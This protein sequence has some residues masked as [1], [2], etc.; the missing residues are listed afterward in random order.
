[1]KGMLFKGC[2]LD[3]LF[4]PARPEP[5]ELAMLGLDGARLVA[6]HDRRFYSYVQRLHVAGFDVAAVL[7]RE[8]FNTTNYRKEAAQYAR[9]L[10]DWQPEIYVIGNEEDAGLLPEESPSS[11]KMEPAEYG[12]FFAACADGIRSVD[13]AA[14]LIMGGLVSGQ[15]SALHDYLAALGPWRQWLH[16]YDVHPYTRDASSAS[17]LLS[18]YRFYDPNLAQYVLEWNRPANEIAAY[19]LMLDNVLNSPVA[20]WC[21]AMWSSAMVPDMG[22]VDERGWIT[23]EGRALSRAL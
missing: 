20:G 4:A 11:W 1:M 7:A 22:L 17:D 21:W 15:P 3:S 8:S 2:C 14:L 10:R 12:A 19:V 18:A 5:R 16:G 13:P 23:P 6:R 9:G